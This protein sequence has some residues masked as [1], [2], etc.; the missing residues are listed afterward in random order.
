MAHRAEFQRVLMN[1]AVGFVNAPLDVLDQEI[2][3]ALAEVGQFSDSDRAYVFDYNFEVR[4]TS[5]THEWCG[6]GVEPM[7][8]E[9]QDVPLEGLEDWLNAHGSHRM[10]HVPSVPDLPIGSALREILEPQGI[11]TLITVPLWHEGRALGFVGFDAVRHRKDWTEDE[12]TLLEVLAELF[13]NA[14]VRRDRENELIRARQE[15]EQASIA[16]SR[17]LATM[18]HELRTPMNGVLGMTEL[19][20][21]SDLD[22]R[23]QKFA[24]AVHRS[25]DQLMH[26]LNDVL[27][28]AKVESGRMELESAAFDPA[29]LTSDIVELSAPGAQSKQ[30]ELVVTLADDV[31]PAVFGDQGRIRQII[32]NLVG[33]AI[34]FTESGRVQVNLSV[35]EHRGDTVSL[36]WQVADTGPGIDPEVLPAVFE[37][38]TQADTAIARK[39]GGT[40]L[41]LTIVRELVDLMGGTLAASSTRGEGSEFAVTLP[42]QVAEASAAEA[43]DEPPPAVVTE[44]R[45]PAAPKPGAGD[46]E[47]AK[48]AAE[49]LAG[50]RV[51]VAEDNTVNRMLAAAHLKALGC[52]VL[53]A[54]DGK[55]ALEVLASSGVDV[56]LMDCR[57]PVMDG[58]EA[59]SAIRAGEGGQVAVPIIALTANAMADDRDAC[60]AVGM[61]GFLAKP[62]TRDALRS[63]LQEA[64]QR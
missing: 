57:M 32:S 27:D 59:T 25:G 8:D 49:S 7:I 23:Q 62:Y 61:D 50:M 10:M 22:A 15:A 63:V 4:T 14:W 30:L 38:F 58:F 45:A 11:L 34:K 41:G 64:L 18:S 9:L 13:T 6:P 55:E 37:P 21:S 2:D 43:A 19:L 60:L 52:D 24:E 26:L 36:R 39:Y 51:L 35:T 53:M 17:F 1:L 29:R 40:G 3:H 46:S 44:P 56:V 33:N 42:L 47:A 28:V 16:K 12:L 20:L 48:G 5:N 31:P 54:V